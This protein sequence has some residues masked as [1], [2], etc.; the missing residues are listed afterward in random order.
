MDELRIGSASPYDPVSHQSN[1]DSRNRRRKKP[2]ETPAAEDVV[3]LSGQSA[4]AEEPGTGYAPNRAE[5][6]RD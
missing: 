3:S 5:D 1:E 6:S 2:P 4:D